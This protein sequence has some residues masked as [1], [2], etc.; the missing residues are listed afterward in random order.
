MLPALSVRPRQFQEPNYTVYYDTC[1]MVSV[2]VRL[3][4]RSDSMR[5]GAVPYLWCRQMTVNT[6][7]SIS[8]FTLRAENQNL[9]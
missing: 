8:V 3:K 1:N 6:L 2:V 4:V 7:I 5:H 9:L